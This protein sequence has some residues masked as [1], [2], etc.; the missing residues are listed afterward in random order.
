MTNT[1]STPQPTPPPPRPSDDP[2]RRAATRTY[3][4]RELEDLHRALSTARELLKWI[5]EG[6]T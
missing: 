4:L 5:E 6:L 3:T 1:S 2:P